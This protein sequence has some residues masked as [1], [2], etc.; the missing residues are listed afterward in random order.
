M[1]EA[2]ATLCSRGIA[3]AVGGRAASEIGP[4]QA[5]GLTPVGTMTEFAAYARGL[6]AAVAARS[7]A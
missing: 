5:Q 6:R 4:P 2:A 7:R 1:G 3:L